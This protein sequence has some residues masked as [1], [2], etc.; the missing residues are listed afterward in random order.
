MT[1][2]AYLTK[3]R[4]YR[5]KK[6]AVE[7]KGGRCQRCGWSGNIS[8]FH[9]HHRDPNQKEFG[10]S[11]STTNWEKYWSEAEKCDLLCAN[12]HSIEHSD[13]TDPTFLSDVETYSGRVLEKTDHV[14]KNQ[15]PLA[16]KTEKTCDFCQRVFVPRTIS[17][18]FCSIECRS[19]S[20]RRCIRPTS[21]ELHELLRTANVNQISKKYGVTFNTVKKWIAS[22]CSSTVEQ[23]TDNR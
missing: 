5:M 20:S 10:I 17:Q 8:A 12:C 16:T 9:F 7:L 3:I 22:S 23:P 6:K 14:W 1:K 15:N 11:S 18:K 4:R 2:Q 13:Y 19:I 21:A